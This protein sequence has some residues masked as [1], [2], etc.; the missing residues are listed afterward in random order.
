MHQLAR[1]EERHLLRA[2]RR[3]VLDHVSRVIERGSEKRCGSGVVLRGSELD[4]MVGC[5]GVP[6]ENVG[7]LVDV[8]LCV[9][10]VRVGRVERRGCTHHE[11]LHELPGKVLVRVGSF[12]L[13][14]VQ[15]AIERIVRLHVLEHGQIAAGRIG[16]EE[17]MKLPDVAV[18]DPVVLV[19]RVHREH[20]LP[21]VV[22]LE[23]G[24]VRVVHELIG[25]CHV[26]ECDR[27]RVAARRGAERLHPGLVRRGVCRGRRREQHV[28]GVRHRRGG[29]EARDIGRSR[30]EQHPSSQVF[31]FRGSDLRC[32]VRDERRHRQCHDDGAR[33]RHPDEPFL[34]HAPDDRRPALAHGERSVR[35]R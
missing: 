12:R 17:V 28:H 24:L 6:G 9:V 2:L 3:D 10:G 27:V 7:E 11:Q 30:V 4:L 29:A 13:G 23:L 5:R 1:E 8:R 35:I 18:G 19:L 16:V 15:V 34:R 14:Q 32:G 20:V 33:D 21:Q 26:G 25:V 31:G 22:E